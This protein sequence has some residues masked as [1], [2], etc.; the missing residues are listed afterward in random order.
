MSTLAQVRVDLATN[1]ATIGGLEVYTR[2]PDSVEVPCAVVGMPERAE[3][4][5]TYGPTFVRYIVPVQLLVCRAD[6][7][8]AQIALDVYVAPTGVTSVKA[9]VEVAGVTS[10]WHFC[11]VAEARDFA[12]YEVA[13]IHYLGC[14]FPVEV[15]VS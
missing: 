10:G 11:N 14:V 1:L 4:G 5:L 8:E 3:Y 15:V 9:A 12:D 2:R 7:E 13:G 6:A